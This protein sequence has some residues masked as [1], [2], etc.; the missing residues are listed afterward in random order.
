MARRSPPMTDIQ[1]RMLAT[2]LTLRIGVGVIG[3]IFPIL[4]WAGGRARSIHLAD[5]MSASYHAHEGCLD[6]KRPDTCP[7]GEQLK[8]AGPMR[9]CFV[10]ILFII[11]SVM[12]LMKGFSNLENWALNV[13]GVMA[14]GVALFPMPWTKTA[15]GFSPHGIC[16]IAFFICIAFACAFCSG[17]TLKH[18]PPSPD[19]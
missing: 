9:N 3:I 5:S 18:M 12:Y 10:G 15:K 2:F 13:A 8:G 7:E 11:G 4:L 14:L 19:R 17:K 6:P 16:A 1:K